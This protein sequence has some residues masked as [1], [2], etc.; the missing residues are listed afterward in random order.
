MILKVL[1]CLKKNGAVVEDY[2]LL[3][4]AFTI[5]F[6]FAFAY[7]TIDMWRYLGYLIP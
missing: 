3:L 5:A 7:A 2:L 6:A 4:W 1:S